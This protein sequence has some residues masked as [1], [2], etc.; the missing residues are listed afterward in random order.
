MVRLT[1]DGSWWIGDKRYTLGI[2]VPEGVSHFDYDGT[3]C[4]CFRIVNNE[5]HQFE[6]AEC[7]TIAI[8]LENRAEEIEIAEQL[9]VQQ[10]EQAAAEARA[11]AEAAIPN[12]DKR[13][14]RY[15]QETDPLLMVVL[16]YMIEGNQPAKLE[17]AKQ[18]YLDK[19]AQIR[20]ELP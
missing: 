7:L 6:N 2:K 10:A 5:V 1:R 3:S 8:D 19:K 14:R 13:A 9:K 15:K 12:I 11:A 17:I 20:S 18:A 4:K 16:G